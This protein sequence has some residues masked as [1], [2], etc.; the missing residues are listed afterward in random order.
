MAI[1]RDSIGD[2]YGDML[3]SLYGELFSAYLNAGVNPAAKQEADQKFSVGVAL[4]MAVRDR[5][6]ALLPPNA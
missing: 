3:K 5:A 4:A 2:A 1:G 6:L